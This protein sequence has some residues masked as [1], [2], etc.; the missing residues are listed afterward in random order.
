MEK[1]LTRLVSG[2]TVAAATVGSAFL[3]SIQMAGAAPTVSALGNST[4]APDPGTNLDPMSSTTSGGCPI[5]SVQA[6]L[7]VVGPLETDPSQQVFPASK[8]YGAVAPTDTQFS[9]DGPFVQRWRVAFQVAVEERLGK[10]ALVP[11]GTYEFT[12]QCVDRLGFNPTGTFVGRLK[13]DTPTTYH[14]VKEATPTPPASTPPPTQT[15]P[16]TPTATP[17]ATPARPPGSTATTTKLHRHHPHRRPGTSVRRLRVRRLLGA[18]CGFSFAHRS[19][20]SDRPVVHTVHVGQRDVHVPKMLNGREPVAF[21]LV[22]AHDWRRCTTG[23]AGH[24]ARSCAQSRPTDIPCGGV[25]HRLTGCRSC[26]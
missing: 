4:V 9:N 12:A 24:T 21:A 3:V 15:P 17:T 5:P 10:G 6:N 20:H 23:T 22:M 7:K 2:A 19:V 14:G 8:P 11:T 25:R 26:S 18:A 13:F 16:P 1:S